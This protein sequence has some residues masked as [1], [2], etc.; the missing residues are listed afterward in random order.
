MT[1]K[2]LLVAHIAVLGYW[3]GSELVIN[4]TFRYVS[5]ARDLA[6]T[7]R[8]RL[9]DHVMVVDQHVRYALVLQF[10]LGFALAF[11]LAYLPGGD[12]A[13]WA[14]GVAGLAWLILVETTHRSRKSRNG[15]GLAAFDRALRYGVM[16]GLIL[17]ATGALMGMGPGSN[18]PRWLALK[19]VCFAAVM[20]C[21]VGI[22]RVLIRLAPVWQNLVTEGSTADR[23]QQ[24]RLLYKQATSVLV[25]LWMFIGLMV[26]LS[27][28]KP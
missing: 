11:K 20:G 27:V 25:L 23:E 28:W 26:W 21:G 24:I 18:L 1:L 22:R 12:I 14:V 3:L 2:L 19:L 10:T 17:L 6:V 8:D 7:E 13:A 16:V 15:P 4:S 5:W 9:M